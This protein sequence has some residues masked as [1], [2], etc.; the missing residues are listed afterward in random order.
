MLEVR[1][2][3]FFLDDLDLFSHILRIR[4]AEEIAV[5]GS[6]EPIVSSFKL[7]IVILIIIT[8]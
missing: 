5:S 3:F 2:V 6:T 8:F 4:V 7:I 1:V